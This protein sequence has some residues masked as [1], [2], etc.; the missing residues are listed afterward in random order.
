MKRNSVTNC[1]YSRKE[2]IEL[3]PVPV[4]IHE[5]V[6]EKIVYK[7]L[8]LIGVNIVYEDLNTCHCT[9]LS[10]RVIIKFKSCKQKQ[11]LTYKRTD[12]EDLLK[13]DNLEKYIDNAAF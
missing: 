3:Y 4:E 5:D 6:L 12:I 1:Q 8:S 9:K 10:G 7:A 13:T 2:T 11:S